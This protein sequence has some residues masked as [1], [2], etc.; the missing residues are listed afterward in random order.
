M[1]ATKRWSL[2]YRLSVYVRRRISVA[3]MP[4]NHLRFFMYGNSRIVG[5]FMYVLFTICSDREH[6]YVH[7]TYTLDTLQWGKNSIPSRY[8]PLGANVQPFALHAQR[9]PVGKGFAAYIRRSNPVEPFWH[10]YTPWT[11]PLPY[12]TMVWTGSYTASTRRP[13]VTAPHMK[14]SLRAMRDTDWERHVYT[15]S[16]LPN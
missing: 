12:W 6:L 13:T 8:M 5:A 1:S 3:R 10:H 2:V 9:R 15:Q 4:R 11:P 7:T 14:A 16:H